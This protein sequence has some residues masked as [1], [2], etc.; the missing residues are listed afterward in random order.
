M[1]IVDQVN[2]QKFRLNLTF[3]KFHAKMVQPWEEEVPTTEVV[4]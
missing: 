1:L 2:S 4:K 3:Q